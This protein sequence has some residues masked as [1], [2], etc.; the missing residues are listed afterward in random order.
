M[1]AQ[2]RGRIPFVGI[3]ITLAA[4]IVYV[5]V[6]AMEGGSVVNVPLPS[7]ESFLGAL[8]LAAL[9]EF[10]RRFLN[11]LDGVGK[12]VDAVDAKVESNNSQFKEFRATVETVLM[13]VDGRGGI[14]NDVRELQSHVFRD[15]GAAP[16][17]VPSPVSL[18]FPHSQSKAMP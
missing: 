7:A 12:K 1:T 16:R 18:Q 8:L 5:G 11:K 3:A 17:G 15:G 4:V 6:T 2:Q 10:G 13:D 9:V 14:V